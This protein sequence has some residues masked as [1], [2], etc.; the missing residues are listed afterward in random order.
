MFTLR[1]SAP[2]R[3]TALVGAALAAL[4]AVSVAAPGTA[5]AQSAEV[6]SVPLSVASSGLLPGSVYS[7]PTG[8]IGSG[9]IGLGS[10][11]VPE[12]AIGSLAVEF[13]GGYFTALGERQAE[14]D[15]EPAE[16]RAVHETVVGSS[17]AGTVVE[18]AA[19]AAD[20]ALPEPVA[21]SIES[22]HRA[23]AEDPFEA[24]ARIDRERV[25]DRERAVEA[26]R[27]QVAGGV[28]GTRPG[29]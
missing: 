20:V 2:L 26:G 12:Y 28:V 6:G 11:S 19:R 3:T 15:L 22:V 14:G 9:T 21:G 10:V 18:D 24:A 8:S 4:T 27:G 29:A 13:V 23:A 25:T 1:P 7:N 16:I 5:R 17:Q